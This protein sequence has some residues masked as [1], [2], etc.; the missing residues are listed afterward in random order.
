MLAGVEL[1]LMLI[2]GALYKEEEET[3]AD[4][5][6]AF[7]GYSTFL[8]PWLALGALL[9]L[10]ALRLL[11]REGNERVLALVLSPIVVVPVALIFAVA[12]SFEALPWLVAGCILYG[13]FVRLPAPPTAHGSQAMT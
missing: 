7:A 2:A 12:G 11:Q 13:L 4:V 3:W 5:L 9:Y 10:L 6:V 8:Y 1:G